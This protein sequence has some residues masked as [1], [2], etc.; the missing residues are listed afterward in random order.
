MC[1]RP[2]HR[3]LYAAGALGPREQEAAVTDQLAQFF[4]AAAARRPRAIRVIDWSCEAWGAGCF[5][6]V[7]PP[8]LAT[9][10]ALGG[11]ALAAPVHGSEGG[12]VFFAATELAHAWP[13][14]FEGALDAGYRAATEAA[15]FLGDAA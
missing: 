13:G 4:A 11:T 3:L 12:A 14:Y 9:S 10:V 5:A 7:W 6:C 8:G 15:N 2:C 1:L